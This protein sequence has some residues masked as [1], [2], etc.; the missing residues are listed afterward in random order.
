MYSGE[1]DVCDVTRSV[2]P[3]RAS[4]KNMPGH[5]GNRTY[6]LWNKGGAAPSGPPVV[7]H[8]NSAQWETIYIC[9]FSSWLSNDVSSKSRTLSQG[10]ITS[11]RFLGSTIHATSG[12]WRHNMVARFGFTS[13]QSVVYV[14]GVEI[15][16]T[17]R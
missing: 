13:G 12:M 8:C 11:L 17:I 6:D 3:H 7:Y 16:Q 5:G 9:I 15:S 2:Y 14:A 1:Y 4:L 10:N